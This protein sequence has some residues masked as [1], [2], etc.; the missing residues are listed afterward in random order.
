MHMKSAVA[1]VLL[2]SSMNATPALA[3]EDRDAAARRVQVIYVHPEKFVDLK[4]A[5]Y[6]R[7]AARQAY[8]DE[9]ERHIRRRAGTRVPDG[10]Q[11]TV[12]VSQID[13]A[14]SF[15]PWRGH[16]GHVRIVRDVYPPRIDLD[17]VLSAAN[18]KV[19]KSGARKLRDLSF[20]GRPGLY[21]TDALRYEKALVD[22]WLESELGTP[23][24]RTAAA[25][26]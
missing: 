22:D 4:D 2:L 13:M 23:L 15:E 14:G 1:F 25:G 21:G 7:D 26:G 16:A 6:P 19:V 20:L 24:S 12:R 17:F 3:D 9:L 18:G 11:L 8:L 5:Y 10:Q